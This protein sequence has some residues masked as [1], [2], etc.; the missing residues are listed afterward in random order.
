[1][2][3]REDDNLYSMLPA[4]QGNREDRELGHAVNVTLRPFD[5]DDTKFLV[6]SW[7][8]S[9]RSVFRDSTDEDYYSGVQN[10][11]LAIAR[12]ARVI[13]AC[14]KEQPWYIL[15]YCVS[16]APADT[17]CPLVV[18]YVFTKVNYRRCGIARAMLEA[19]GWYTNR[20]VI[21]TNWNYYVKYV[22]QQVRLRYNPWLLRNYT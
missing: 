22:R 3:I 9:M 20:L 6:H 11:I 18:H 14:D 21:A 16:D 10:Q 2:S 8:R 5:V 4:C 12:T 15:G 1:M 17:D 13:V 19:H 7:L